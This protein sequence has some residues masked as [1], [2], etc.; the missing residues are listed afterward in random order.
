MKANRQPQ[1]AEAK[2]GETWLAHEC[3]FCGAKGG[4]YLKHYGIMRCSCGHFVWALRPHRDGPLQLFP[5]PGFY[6]IKE[7]A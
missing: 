4:A 5:Y 3:G 2:T 7:A 6:P 1:M